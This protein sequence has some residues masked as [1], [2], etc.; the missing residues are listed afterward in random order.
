MKSRKIKGKY[1]IRLDRGE[2]ILESMKKF[3]SENIIISGYFF[4][5]GALDEAELA[6]YSVDNKKYSSKRF[7]QPLE[8][9][10]LSGNVSTMNN[11]VYLHCH[12]TLSDPDM[13]AIAGHLVEGRV[14]VT[15]EII[16]ASLDCNITREHDDS[17]GVNLLD[18]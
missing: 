10:N 18:I 9:T 4:G 15:C 3:C 17:T 14:A 12:A 11:E 7:N 1:I 5:I 2:K 16:L 6:H 13:K 8:I